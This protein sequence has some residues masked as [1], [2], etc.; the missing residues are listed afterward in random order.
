[1]MKLHGCKKCHGTLLL[2]KDEFGWYEECIQCGY[3]RDVPVDTSFN[4]PLEEK[5]MPVTV[6][7]DP[8]DVAKLWKTNKVS[9]YR[10]L[11]AVSDPKDT[12]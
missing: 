10:P 11:K 1:M 7:S 6:V 9:A 4:E 3:S 5:P 2:D 8:Q 12:Y